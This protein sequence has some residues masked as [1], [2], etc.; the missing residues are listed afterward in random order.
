MSLR[1]EIMAQNLYL[2]CNCSQFMHVKFC[3]L[4]HGI[5]NWHENVSVTVNKI[6]FDYANYL[7]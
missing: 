4:G 7:S 3:L 5:K 2:I 1:L 6:S